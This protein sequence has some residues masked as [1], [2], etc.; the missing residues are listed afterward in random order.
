MWPFPAKVGKKY[1]VSNNLK[2]GDSVEAGW[3]ELPEGI[4]KGKVYK[5]S[6]DGYTGSVRR[7]IE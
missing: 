5:I 3:L 6:A 2:P 7:K 4:K 1:I